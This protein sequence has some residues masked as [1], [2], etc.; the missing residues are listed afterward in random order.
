LTDQLTLRQALVQGYRTE[1]LDDA[2]RLI[3]TVLGI[4]DGD[5]ASLMFSG[6]EYVDEWP[7]MAEWE[8][9]NKLYAYVEYEMQVDLIGAFHRAEK[10]AANEPTCC[11]DAVRDSGEQSSSDD[12]DDTGEGRCYVRGSD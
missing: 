1:N 5:N 12:S 7:D 2:L 10:E 9:F 8:R 3:Q 6:R 11:R 4:D